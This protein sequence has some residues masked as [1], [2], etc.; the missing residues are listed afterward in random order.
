MELVSIDGYCLRT[1]EEDE[2]AIEEEQ[3]ILDKNK[4]DN[5]KKGAKK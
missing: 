1:L 3:N 4:K 5:K 2:K